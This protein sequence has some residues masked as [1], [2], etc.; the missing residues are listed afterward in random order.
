MAAGILSK[1][2]SKFGPCKTPCQHIDCAQTRARAAERCT[3]C[4]QA[5]GYNVRMYQLESQTVHAVCHEDAADRHE[6]R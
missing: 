3:Y 5:I 1:P 6:L 2:G 4:R